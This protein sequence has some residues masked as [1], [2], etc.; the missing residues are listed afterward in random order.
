MQRLNHTQKFSREFLENVPADVAEKEIKKPLDAV[1]V[2]QYHRGRRATFRGIQ[3][4]WDYEDFAKDMI[5]CMATWDIVRIPRYANPLAHSR[6]HN[7]EKKISSRKHP[8]F[9]RSKSL[10]YNT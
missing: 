3:F 6:H 7:R 5:T 1:Q 9:K 10:I 8:L 2:E 4:G